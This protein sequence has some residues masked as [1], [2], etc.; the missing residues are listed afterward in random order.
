M[1][2]ILFLVILLCNSY[3]FEYKGMSL[4]DWSVNG[5]YSVG[6]S[7]DRLKSDNVNYVAINVFVYQDTYES[8]YIYKDGQ[9]TPSDGAVIYAIQ[10]A[11]N[12]GMGVLLKV[13]VDSKDD[14]W[15]GQFAPSN[16]D[17]WFASYTSIMT[18]YARIAQ[19]NGVELFSVG[20]EYQS[21]SGSANKTRWQN[22]ITAIKNVY[23]G[24]LVYSAN[25][26]EYNNVSFWDSLDFIG[27]DAYFPLDDDNNATADKIKNDWTSCSAS[28]YYGVNWI[29]AI[30]TFRQSKGKDVIFTEI[31]YPSANGGAKEPWR[32]DL[33]PVN[34]TLQSNCYRGTILAW[35]DFPWFKG[36]FWWD[37]GVYLSGGGSSD[38]HH[39]P[40][41]KP[42]EKVLKELYGLTGGGSTNTNNGG[43]GGTTNESPS[44]NK[45]EFELLS[46]YPNPVFISSDDYVTIRYKLYNNAKIRI[47]LYDL[48]MNLIKDLYNGGIEKEAG[49][50]SEDIFDIKYFKSEGIYIFTIEAEF[51]D[52]GVYSSKKVYGKIKVIK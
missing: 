51:N 46:P 50:H 30:D 1:L 48:N 42:A 19:N 22:V 43:G 2:I 5:Y 8:T 6:G 41:N 37:W 27:I 25:W 3:A 7:L 29:Y 45:F 10:Q 15:R 4:T 18:Q 52:S 23:T 24:P 44:F 38:T 32:W 28:G 40:M 36:F 14:R 34:L 20:C 9:K 39:T 13:N 11:H 17:A 12:R 31:G 33:S 26:T 47:K 21:L 49:I 16:V 35:K